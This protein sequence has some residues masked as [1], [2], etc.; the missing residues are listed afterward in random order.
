MKKRMRSRRPNFNQALVDQPLLAVNRRLPVCGTLAGLV[1]RSS[2]RNFQGRPHLEVCKECKKKKKQRGVE[3]C[4][5]M[6]RIVGVVQGSKNSAV[7]C[8]KRC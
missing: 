4:A 7:E 6:L 5:G 3:E 8:F 2:K 1:K